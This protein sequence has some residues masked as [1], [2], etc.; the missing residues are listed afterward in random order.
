M[1]NEN[2]AIPRNILATFSWLFW[3]YGLQLC[4]DSL[5]QVS[6]ASFPDVTGKSETKR[7]KIDKQYKKVLFA[8]EPAHQR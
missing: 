6:S 8:L 4:F 2:S 7:E 1:C 5:S 3:F